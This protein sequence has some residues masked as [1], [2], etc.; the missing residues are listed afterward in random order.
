MAHIVVFDQDVSASVQTLGDDQ[1]NRSPVVIDNVLWCGTSAIAD[2]ATYRLELRSSGP[3]PASGVSTFPNP[4][5]RAAIQLN[6]AAAYISSIAGLPDGS[7]LFFVKATSSANIKVYR[8]TP[9]IP[10]RPEGQPDPP[11]GTRSREVD[12]AQFSSLLP[13][14]APS[15]AATLPLLGVLKEEALAAYNNSIRI[16]NSSGVW[17]AATVTPAPNSYVVRGIHSFQDAL[18]LFVDATYGA[19]QKAEVWKYPGAGAAITLDTSNVGGASAVWNATNTAGGLFSGSLYGCWNDSGATHRIVKRTTAGAWSV[20]KTGVQVGEI[21][22]F[23]GAIY[24]QYTATL[25][26]P[27]SDP[28]GTWATISSAFQ[29]DL[30]SF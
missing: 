28:T 16:R 25:K 14:D 13:D 9:E 22:E 11:L 7:I 18:F 30:I 4:G 5:T 19:T 8:Y 21:A 10:L 3:I 2:G 6:D 23:R 24:G 15:T 12:G 26:S 29:A 1:K 17:A 27:G 20:A